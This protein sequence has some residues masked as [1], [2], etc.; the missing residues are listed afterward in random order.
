MFVEPDGLGDCLSGSADGRLTGHHASVTSRGEMET[1][2]AKARAAERG[3]NPGDE[4]SE[5]FAAA[6]GF[7]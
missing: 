7:S 1:V 2:I 6:F 5:Y 3:E 4:D